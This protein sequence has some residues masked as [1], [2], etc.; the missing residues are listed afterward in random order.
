MRLGKSCAVGRGE[1]DGCAWGWSGSG[2]M[3][4]VL[5]VGEVA[6][7]ETRRGELNDGLPGGKGGALA[8]FGRRPRS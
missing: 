1:V 8:K 4:M 5:V 6:R 2:G 3:S 7:A